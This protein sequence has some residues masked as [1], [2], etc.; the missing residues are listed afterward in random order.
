MSVLFE[1]DR[2]LVRQYTLDDAPQAFVIYSDPEVMRFLGT[3]GGKSLESV[4]KMRA[5]IAD[6]YL[7]RYSATPQFG[8]WAA[9]RKS[10][11][12]IVGTILLKDL[13]GQPEIEVGW[14]LARFAWGRGYAT[15]GA[16]GAMTHGFDIAKLDRIV[17]VVHPD[18]LKSQAVC[19]RLLMR[20]AGTKNAYQQD[21][22]YFIAD[23]EPW[24]N[25]RT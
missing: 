18:N 5:A 9:E 16:R 8:A 10:D 4:E 22:Q 3:P 13:D 12:K 7:P 14:H 19:R 17:A 2:L 23:R 24:L 6:R 20:H 21:L 25:S 15:E 1:T 11:R